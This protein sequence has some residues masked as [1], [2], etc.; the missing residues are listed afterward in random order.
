MSP[1]APVSINRR[2]VALELGHARRD[3]VIE[4][5]DRAV[6]QHH[7]VACMQIAVEQAVH[8]AASVKAAACRPG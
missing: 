7:Q 8:H 1:D 4:Q 3:A 6:A 2:N 5:P